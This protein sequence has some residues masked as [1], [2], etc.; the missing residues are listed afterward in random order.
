VTTRG[1]GNV[2]EEPG[3][4]GEFS[5]LATFLVTELAPPGWP[6]GG[7]VSGVPPATGSAS[8]ISS[9]AAAGWAASGAMWLTGHSDGPPLAPGGAVVPALA[10]AARAAEHLARTLGGSLSVDVASLLTGRAALL[11]LRRAGRT[12][13]NGSCRLLRAADGWVAVNLARP[14]DVELIPALLERPVPGDPWPALAAA[15][16]DLPCE[17]L[18]A[19]AGLLG[20]PAAAL[21]DR[22]DS[23]DRSGGM[24]GSS[25]SESPVPVGPFGVAAAGETRG[26]ANGHERLV[27]DLSSMWAGPLCAHLLGRAGFRVVKVESTARPDGAR[28]G[29]SRFYSWLHAGHESVAL[30]L[31]SEDGRRALR[32]L[33]DRADVVIEASRPRAVAQM[34][35]DAHES[36][37]RRPGVTWVGITGHGRTGEAGTRVAFGDDAAVAA[38]LVARDRRGD[39][40]FCGDAIADPVTGLYAAVGA[41]ASQAAGGGHLLDVAMVGA[42]AFA[43][44]TPVAPFRAVEAGPGRWEVPAGAGVEPQ[45]V[46]P[47]APPDPPAGPARSLGADTARVLAELALARARESGQ[48]GPSPDHPSGVSGTG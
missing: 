24:G 19:R 38:G 1:D 43:V 28:S 12:S 27:V 45:P 6:P 48:P 2:P 9:A 5:R 18:V 7:D 10:A 35:I 32:D 25:G 16:A 13:A 36:V 22:P 47:P 34:G 17:A 30:D 41:L 39:P 21:A 11:G 29:D 42:S 46:V 31:S 40:V 44:A 33:V 26:E 8:N 20:L 4:A 37:A 3:E 15:V 23:P 14:S